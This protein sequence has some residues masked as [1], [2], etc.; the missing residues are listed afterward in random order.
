MMR[1]LHLPLVDKTDI[2]H[3][4]CCNMNRLVAGQAMAMAYNLCRSFDR[5]EHEHPLCGY[6][7]VDAAM[8]LYVLNEKKINGLSF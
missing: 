7:D 4:S 5:R 2:D 1:R 6:C 8:F 3:C